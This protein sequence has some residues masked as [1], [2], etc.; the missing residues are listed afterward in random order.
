MSSHSIPVVSGPSPRSPG[1][2]GAENRPDSPGPIRAMQARFNRST[3]SHWDHFAAH[4]QRI[5]QLLLPDVSHPAGRLCVL[6]AGNCNDLDLR[7]LCERFDEIHLI[8]LDPAALEA[9]ARRQGVGERRSVHLHAPIDLTGIADTQGA[10]RDRAPSAAAISAVAC[11]AEEAPL[12]E[13]D[14]LA[15]RCDVVLSPCIL[16][17]IVGYARDALGRGHPRAAEL[18]TVVR[19]RHLR[20]IVDLL[21]PGG[22]G[23]LVSDLATAGSP[24]ELAAPGACS[25]ELSNVMNKLVRRRDTFAGLDPDAVQAVLC[26]DP[27]VAPLVGGVQFI[28]PW[29]WTV[30]PA[31]ALL[32][33]ALR[34][35]RAAGTVLLPG[36][37]KGSTAGGGAPGRPLIIEP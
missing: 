21:S 23:L 18:R 1:A 34:L 27:R 33:Y 36:P 4:R 5:E 26:N 19:Q 7:R 12:A 10:W 8:D 15:G 16:S 20:L 3:Q 17:Q 25:G 24:Q 28:R 35:R 2:S 9:A 14:A 6:G 31:K 11:R 13:L 30:G 22:S 37:L 32:V 29:L